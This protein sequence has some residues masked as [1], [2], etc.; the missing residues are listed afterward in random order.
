MSVRVAEITVSRSR[1]GPFFRLSSPI[2][3]VR[4][5]CLGVTRRG[6]CVWSIETADYAARPTYTMASV[7]F[8]EIEVVASTPPALGAEFEDEH[9]DLWASLAENRELSEVRYGDVPPGFVQTHPQRSQAPALQVGAEYEVQ[10][11]G[12]SFGIAAFVA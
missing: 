3:P 11:F 4:I 9:L 2:G 5:L 1:R 8:G 6:R 10:V 7:V 12:A